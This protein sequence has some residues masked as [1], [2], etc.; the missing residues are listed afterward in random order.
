MISLA[1]ALD[2]N[3]K[4]ASGGDQDPKRQARGTQGKPGKAI[5]GCFGGLLGVSCVSLA[6][7]GYSM[8]FILAGLILSSLMSVKPV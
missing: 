5:V 2:F 1:L 4:A 3:K 6:F 7:F 8:D